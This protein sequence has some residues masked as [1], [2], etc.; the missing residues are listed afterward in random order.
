[1]EILP[2][3]WCFFQPG[4]IL[5]F[6]LPGLERLA[7]SSRSVY[8]PHGYSP[9]EALAA[10]G[11]AMSHSHVAQ[12]CSKT[13][14]RLSGQTSAF[15]SFPALPRVSGSASRQCQH[16]DTN[17]K[18]CSPSGNT[19]NR[20]L[21]TRLRSCRAIHSQGG[22]WRGAAAP[23]RPGPAAGA[24]T[25]LPLVLGGSGCGGQSPGCQESLSAKPAWR[26][27]LHCSRR[28]CCAHQHA[29]SARSCPQRLLPFRILA[30]WPLCAW[31]V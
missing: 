31:P 5:G 25:H 26:L 22:G 3:H 15:C 21:Q 27:A 4:Q 9:A 8:T 6:L 14:P 12:P 7:R 17:S 24:R 16:R 28:S 13:S 18:S 19:Y 1:M 20:L 29:L 23:L 30:L 2:T 11:A 10:A